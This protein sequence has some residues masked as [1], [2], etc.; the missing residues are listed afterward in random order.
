VFS[1]GG[2]VEVTTVEALAFSE[3]WA[4]GVDPGP[5]DESAQALQFNVTLNNPAD[6]NAFLIPPQISDAGILS[7]TA[8]A[9]VLTEPRVIP[10]TVA[11][12][13]EQGGSTGP[14]T[15]TLTIT[16]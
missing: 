13:D 1:P 12:S 7:F 3:Q 10:M 6:A 2:D 15:L 4:T 5:P 14:V 8:L 11:L 16:P 9:L